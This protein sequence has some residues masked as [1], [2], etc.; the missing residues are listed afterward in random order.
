MQWTFPRF[1]RQLIEHGIVERLDRDDTAGMEVHPDVGVGRFV[2]TDPDIDIDLD[3]DVD[4]TD[5]DPLM[6]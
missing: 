3:E 5:L 4:C 1:I 6:G 2:L